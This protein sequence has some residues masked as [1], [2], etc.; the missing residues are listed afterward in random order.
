MISIQKEIRTGEGL[1]RLLERTMLCFQG[2][3]EDAR[4]YAID[5]GPLTRVYQAALDEI[6][7]STAKQEWSTNQ[8]EQVRS[9]VQAA[10]RSYQQKAEQQLC[11]LRSDFEQTAT[12]LAAVLKSLEYEDPALSLR[13]QVK[14]L[15]ELKD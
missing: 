6:I 8:V 9:R 3:V 1:Q 12:S 15:E 14:Q 11:R 4:R 7:E 13:A 5:F 2:T 10:F